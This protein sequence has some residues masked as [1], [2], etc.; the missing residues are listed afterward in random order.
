MT[1]FHQTPCK[2]KPSFPRMANAWKRAVDDDRLLYYNDWAEYFRNSKHFAHSVKNPKSIENVRRVYLLRSREVHPDKNPNRQQNATEAF[3]QLGRYFSL[4]TNHFASGHPPPGNRGNT[5]PPPPA[6]RQNARPPTRS[7]PRGN[8]PPKNART[9]PT[10]SWQ[11]YWPPSPPPK[12]PR[13]QNTRPG[14][15]PKKDRTYSAMATRGY[16]HFHDDRLCSTR[17]PCSVFRVPCSDQVTRG[18]KEEVQE[19]WSVVRR[20]LIAFL[21]S[22]LAPADH[23]EV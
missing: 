18:R 20:S 8:T 15:L 6:P 4:A 21:Q 9:Q 3:K 7:R 10:S 19:R 22:R 5:R 2:I 17:V 23:P 11:T 13:T 1:L 12:R 16:T 14:E